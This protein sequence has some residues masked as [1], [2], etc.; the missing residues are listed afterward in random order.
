M[1]NG[2]NIPKRTIASLQRDLNI[3]TAALFQTLL[4]LTIRVFKTFK[5]IVILSLTDLPTIKPSDKQI[6]LMALAVAVFIFFYR[7]KRK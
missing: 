7:K 5:G 3:A 2:H 1:R 6:F 4:I